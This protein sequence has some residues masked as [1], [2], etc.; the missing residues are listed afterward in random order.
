MDPRGSN[1]G[2]QTWQE[3]PLSPEASSGSLAVSFITIALFMID[4]KVGSFISS[5][6][7]FYRE[8]GTGH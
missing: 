5:L 7:L 8:K 1:S 2:C 4:N 3:A 6:S